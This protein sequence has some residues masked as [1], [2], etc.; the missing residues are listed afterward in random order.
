MGKSRE[1][2]RLLSSTVYTMHVVKALA[3]LQ[4]PRLRSPGSPRR[5]AHTHIRVH[6]CNEILLL[7][8]N[9]QRDPTHGRGGGC[10]DKLYVLIRSL[11][12]LEKGG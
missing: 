10:V 9:V 3:H 7:S 8:S 4:P 5:A 11:E 12:H 6:T 2:S 1:S